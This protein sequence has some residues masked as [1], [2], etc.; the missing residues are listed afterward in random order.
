MGKHPKSTIKNQHREYFVDPN[1]TIIYFGK[2]GNEIIISNC[3]IND[4]FIIGILLY[5][6]DLLQT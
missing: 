1:H 5:M 2:R 4:Y 6:I 3:D